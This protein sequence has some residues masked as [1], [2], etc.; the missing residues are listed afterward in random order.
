MVAKGK[1]SLKCWPASPDKPSN[2]YVSALTEIAKQKAVNVVFHLEIMQTARTINHHTG[3]MY[4]HLHACQRSERCRVGKVVH[5][6]FYVVRTNR[7]LKFYKW[8]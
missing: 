7:G 5:T 3:E 4:H 6:T 1:D 2:E 8:R